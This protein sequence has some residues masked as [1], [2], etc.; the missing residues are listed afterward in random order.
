MDRRRFIDAGVVAG[1]WALPTLHAVRSPAHAAVGSPEPPPPPTATCTST[2]FDMLLVATGV[3]NGTVGPARALPG[4]PGSFATANLPAIGFSASGL[5]AEDTSVPPRCGALTR[6]ADLRLDL[7]AVHPDLTVVITSTLL[8]ARVSATCGAPGEAATTVAGLSVSVAGSQVALPPLPPGSTTV[9]P[10]P[11]FGTLSITRD[12]TSTGLGQA[13]ATALRLQL[14]VTVPITGAQQS[15]DVTVA[16][17]E[18]TC[19]G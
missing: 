6:V 5:T 13:R 12:S 4:S 1:V 19:S 10:L 17:A 8:E 16:H 9:V 11:P 14:A 2:G 18:T 3:A 7:R 15:V